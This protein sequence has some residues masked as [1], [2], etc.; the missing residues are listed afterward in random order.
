MIL[1]LLFTYSFIF[2]YYLQT[3]GFSVY[4]F[5][6]IFILFYIYI[7]LFIYFLLTK[8]PAYIFMGHH[9]SVGVETHYGMNGPGFETL[10]GH[11]ILSFPF[12]SRP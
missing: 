8:S 12:P 7:D 10:W 6:S 2:L 11:G 3:N 5:Y 4:S 9:S 1:S